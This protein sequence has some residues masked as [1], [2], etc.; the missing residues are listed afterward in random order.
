MEV[1]IIGGGL[2]GLSIAFELIEREV[3]ITVVEKDKIG[4]GASWVA[5]G[6]L[7]PQSEGLDGEFLNFCLESRNLYED[8]VK[9]IEEETG[10]DTGYWKCGILKLAFSEEEAEKIRQDVG[11]FKKLGLPAQWLDRKELEKE[12]KNL[13]DK[14]IGGALYKE[15]SQVDNRKLCSALAD[16]IKQNAKVLE[17]TKVLKIDEKNG[18][19]NK[20]I[21]DKGEL[22]AEADLCI[23]SAGAWSGKILDIPVFPLKGE[24]LALDIEED[25]ID[26]VLYSSRAYLIPRSDFHRLV[27]G[28]TEENVGFKD[29]NTAYGTLKLLKGSIDTLKNL[30][31]K[32]IQ[33][34][35]FGYR[36]ATPDELPILGDSGI[37]NLILATGHH[38]NGILL[39][40]ITAKII[41]EYIADNKKSKYLELFS[42]ERFKT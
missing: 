18:K 21:T 31:Y 20:I 19:F 14:V 40:P 35:W 41:S 33:E 30:A 37:E 13:G 26:R 22:K 23:L 39:A 15:D 25:E 3:N 6:M 24:M 10:K 29:G 27:V 34:L 5:G 7:A 42:L 16:Y 11:R 36:P 8:F 2:I 32:N 4:K 1:I 9:R 28:A 17:N 38:R 12:Y